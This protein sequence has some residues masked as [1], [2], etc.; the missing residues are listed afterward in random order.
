M[1]PVYPTN[2]DNKVKVAAGW[3]IEQCGL[4]GLKEHGLGV[5]QNQALVLV[6]Y[7]QTEGKYLVDLAQKVKNM[8]REKFEIELEPEVRLIGE[9][10]LLT[11]VEAN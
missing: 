7:N 9:E 4:K 10:G 6:N 5:H 11:S 2:I 1:M 8:V 3:L